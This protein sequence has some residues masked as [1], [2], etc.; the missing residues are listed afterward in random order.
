MAPSWRHPGASCRVFWEDQWFPAIVNKD[1]SISSDFCDDLPTDDESFA[2]EPTSRSGDKVYDSS[3]ELFVGSQIEVAS[4]VAA[5]YQNGQEGNTQNYWFLGL[6]LCVQNSTATVWYY[7]GDVEEGIPI[8]PKNIVSLPQAKP[9][10]L[11]G[12]SLD[13]SSRYTDARVLEVLE[14]KVRLGFT[15]P[16]GRQGQANLPVKAIVER[17]KELLK[18]KKLA[19]W[20]P[21]KK[22]SVTKRREPKAVTRPSSESPN[23]Q[24][25]RSED[26]KPAPRV[27]TKSN[28]R[29]F[30]RSTQSSKRIRAVSDDEILLQPPL[31][32]QR[33]V[34]ATKPCW[35]ASWTNLLQTQ[36]EHE[37][38]LLIHAR[39]DYQ[40]PQ[41]YLD[42][43]WDL[44]VHG[45]VSGGVRFPQGLRYQLY[46]QIWEYLDADPKVWKFPDV[47]YNPEDKDLPHESA[48][49]RTLH[50]LTIQSGAAGALARSL[51]D[52]LFESIANDKPLPRENEL[53]DSLLECGL[54]K[55]LLELLDRSFDLWSRDCA[56][57]ELAKN[58]GHL[59]SLVGWLFVHEGHDLV[60]LLK[61]QARNYDFDYLEW[62][63]SLE[64]WIL[65]QVRPRLAE[66]LGVADA[67]NVLIDIDLPKP[68][69]EVTVID[70]SE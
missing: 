57:E 38:L 56:H 43:L 37:H 55:V 29:S 32:Q 9:L 60:D 4:T 46:Q 58:L 63:M 17:T 6:V 18:G 8:H 39:R 61:K 7:D 64:A 70:D 59:V 65:P 40:P 62:I 30:K 19:K 34:T 48:K 5:R 16:N 13:L 12:R 20:P 49:V 31:K 27:S 15:K 69:A 1:G 42:W 14:G 26:K 45:P 10:F 54:R 51:E 24:I 47:C 23:E 52:I 53:V 35:Q 28:K 22:K 33:K 67:Y 68:P 21:D 50:A 44:V 66:S 11:K 25:T 36:E 2:V 41:Q 3:G